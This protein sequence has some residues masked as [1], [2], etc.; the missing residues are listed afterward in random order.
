MIICYLCQNEI[1]WVG[2]RDTGGV[3]LRYLDFEV[4]G[5]FDSKKPKGTPVRPK[6]EY[7]K[8]KVS[9]SLGGV[10]NTKWLEAFM[11]NVETVPQETS[12]PRKDSN[13]LL[14]TPVFVRHNKSFI[15]ISSIYKTSIFI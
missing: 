9:E 2:R 14:Q 12:H 10:Q 3:S 4:R 6:F 5:L 1:D 13:I 8:L 11:Q 7:S 15:N